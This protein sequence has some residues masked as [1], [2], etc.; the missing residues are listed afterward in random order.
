MIQQF[1][2]ESEK[3]H[4]HTPTKYVTAQFAAESTKLQ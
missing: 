3:R 2:P 4:K 1:Q